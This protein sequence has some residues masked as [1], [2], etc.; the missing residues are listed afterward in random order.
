MATHPTTGARPRGRALCEARP[1]ADR[2]RI[3]FS[4]RLRQSIQSQSAGPTT[5]GSRRSSCGRARRGPRRRAA[6]RQRNRRR[7]TFRSFRQ[8]LTVLPAQAATSLPRSRQSTDLRER[9]GRSRTRMAR[10]QRGRAPCVASPLHLYRVVLPRGWNL[11]RYDQ[12]ASS[13]RCSGQPSSLSAGLPQRLST[14]GRRAP[15]ES[16]HRC[17]S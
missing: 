2:C 16:P 8:M 3:P 13:S 9:I 10:P 6:A 15:P 17:L 14:I 7:S 11:H 5:S 1:R 12:R 4:G